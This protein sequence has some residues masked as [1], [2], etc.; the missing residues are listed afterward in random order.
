MHGTEPQLN[1]LKNYEDTERTVG[2][3][4]GPEEKVVVGPWD[5]VGPGIAVFSVVPVPPSPTCH[6]YT[7]ATFS[8]AGRP[9]LLQGPHGH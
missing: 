6:L 3:V 4:I 7:C 8:P 5:P 9:P 1:R 2:C